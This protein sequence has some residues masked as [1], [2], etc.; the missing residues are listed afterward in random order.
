MLALM[1]GTRPATSSVHLLS[2]AC[3][4]PNLSNQ[5]NPLPQIMNRT[6]SLVIAALTGSTAMAQA[7]FSD[8][9]A[10]LSNESHGAACVA[11][12]D[13][14]GD[15]LDD[16]IQLDM[17]T[18]VYILYQ[19]PDHSF[20]TFDYGEVE[21]SS[22]WGWAMAD[23]NNDGHKDICSGVGTTKFLNITARGVFTLSDLPGPGIFTQ[24]M[25]MAD[26]D[27]DGRVDVFACND[28]GPSN[29]YMT[30]SE[31]VP[32]YTADVMPW[33]TT[34][35][36][37]AGDMSGNYG[38]TC[39]DF[40]NDGD[41]DLHISHCRQGVNSPDDCRR[42]D[43][44]FVNDGNGNY[45]DLAAEYGVQ[46]REQVWTTDF[47]DY[48]NDGDLDIFHTT[49]S[50][51]LQLFENDGTGHYTD[52]T[53]NSGLL[54]TGFFLQGLFRDLD[55]DM[56]LDIVTGSTHFYF[57]GHGDGT[58]SKVDNVFPAS[59]EMHSF[60]FGDFNKDGFEDVYATYGDGY[61]DGDPGFPDKLWMNTPN[62]NHFL[63]VNLEGTVS[64][65]DAVGGRVTITGPWGTM[66]REVHAG[67]SYGI[68]NTFTC[69][70]GLGPNT[71][72][73]T[74]VVTFPSGTV[75]TYTDVNA[76]QNITVVEGGCSSP[77]VSI[78]SDGG[79][80]IWCEGDP[81]ITLSAP[82]LSGYS[83]LWS[84]GSTGAT[85]TAN[86]GGTWSVILDNGDGCPAEALATVVENPDQTPSIMVDGPLSFCETDGP[87]TLTSSA[88][89]GNVWS[90]NVE[91]QSISVN[92]SGTYS[93]TVNGACQQWVS[94]TVT[95]D[96]QDAPAAPSA[97]G[98][99]IAYGM[100]ADLNATGTNVAWYDVADGGTPLAT[101]NAF[102]TP[103]LF[104]TTS[105]WCADRNLSGGETYYGGPV[106]QTNVG[107][108]S[109]STYHLVF[110]AAEDMVIV[111]VKVY[112]GSAGARGI[113]VVDMGD[114]STIADGTFDI[115]AGESR[116]DVDFSVPAGGP[117][118]I[119]FSTQDPDC[120]RD[121]NGS[122][123]AYPF[124]LGGLGSI[125]G[126]TVQGGNTLEYYYFFYDWEVQRPLT[127]CESVRTEVVV[128]V[129]PQGINDGTVTGFSV[130]PVP[131]SALL[132]IDF[133]SL[134]GEVDMDL[135]DVTG[136]IVSA[137]HRTVK[138]TATL[139]MSELARGEYTLRVRHA[140]GLIVSRVVV[141]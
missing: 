38:S 104:N 90:T 74:M 110:E 12:A 100:T 69:H 31:G 46:N 62:G 48:D 96:V 87:V 60:A 140:G 123:P 30:N 71:V 53:A 35:T 65:R 11:V 113:E 92:A 105:Y 107:E 126:T 85:V 20:D 50:S 14:D 66:I 54:Y 72:I 51:T 78:T 106:N 18:H 75:Q 15:G 131:T 7:V 97:N 128:Q 39:T 16:I 57:K 44:L 47:G 129:A 24:A 36:G 135:L 125:T 59:K 77:N 139:D 1:E 70:F 99:S 134:A 130:Y 94:E 63:N 81:A 79:D 8:A 5:P 95:V 112:A 118:G 132:T 33:A 89:T 19:N 42:W 116:V 80:L 115:P 68:T 93:V 26:F 45:A 76:D 124:D 22:Q 29:I 98:A 3:K 67:E 23:L 41:I 83:V 61:V 10:N 138:G 120:W 43:R 49:H 88:L 27:N 91:T 4:E 102:T 101:T 17:S 84:D 56:H 55:N 111:S 58:F 6:Y 2:G 127:S 122:N 64:N 40:D 86:G 82:T 13:M 133:G 108:N 34:C 103:A 28:V 32:V 121:G 136:R 52:V 114:G 21:N 117:Y 141:R 37:T 119:R 73:P 9:S 25:S 137:E 109:N